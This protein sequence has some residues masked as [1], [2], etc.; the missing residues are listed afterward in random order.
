MIM[1]S[2]IKEC[3]QILIQWMC[4]KDKVS[5]QVI[6]KKCEYLNI[7]F[8]L[9]IEKHPIRV[10]FFPL[11]MTGNVELCGDMSFKL[12]PPVCIKKGDLYLYTNINKT[13][14][15]D[16]TGYPLL[17]LSKSE[18]SLAAVTKSYEFNASS[19][20]KSFP[21]IDKVVEN[22]NALPENDFSSLVFSNPRFDYGIAK[23]EALYSSWYFVYP[24]TRKICSIPNWLK[25]PDALN[26]SYC[27]FRVLRGDYNGIY[28]KHSKELK[29]KQFHF[30][31]LLYRVL[32][33][34]SL[35]N[36]GDPY[37]ENGNYI[38]PN[39]KYSI[40]YELNRIMCKSIHYE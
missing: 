6:A 21:R 34:E 18:S 40:V 33:I 37:S 2:K 29:V 30:P 7:Q 28:N 35:L 38:F 16:E 32:L 4:I 5:Y 26:I 31:I 25:Q 9:N 1:K 15:E 12:S 10:I 36:N 19:I 3:Q 17:Y 14:K 23:K 39:I 24:K 22:F 11:F 13:S 27:L 20:L 8:G